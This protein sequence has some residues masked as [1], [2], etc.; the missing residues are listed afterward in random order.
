MQ[1]VVM[2]SRGNASDCVR[3]CLQRTNRSDLVTA[4]QMCLN[5]SLVALMNRLQ[6]RLWVDFQLI[7]IERAFS[8]ESS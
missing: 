2:A 6:W 5:L 7:K 1:S 8:L 4:A 3:G